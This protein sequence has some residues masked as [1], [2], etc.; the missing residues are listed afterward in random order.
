MN[1]R[2]FL[3]VIGQG[4]AAVAGM[5]YIPRFFVDQAYAQ[6]ANNLKIVNIFL[7][8][9]CDWFLTHE[10]TGDATFMDTLKQ[11]RPTLSV[12]VAPRRVLGSTN[13]TVH[14]R[15]A[16]FETAY[17][18]GELAVVM[19][20]GIP[21]FNSGSHEEATN[22]FARGL[23]NGRTT[24]SAGWMQRVAAKYF[25]DQFQ[26]LDLQ[27]GSASTTGGNFRGVFV[28]NLSTFGFNGAAT[29]ESGF[30]LSSAFAA[31]QQ[32]GANPEEIAIQNAWSDT[33]KTVTAVASAVANTTL[34]PVFPTTSIGNQLRDAFRALTNFPTRLVYTATGGYD[35]HSMAD[36]QGQQVATPSGQSRL[37]RDLNDAIAAFKANCVRVG[38]WNDIAIVVTSEF[39]RTNR[40][41]GNTGVDHADANAS[42]IIGGKVNG[43]HYGVAPTS[44]DLLRPQ[45]GIDAKVAVADIY[46]D[47]IVG[48]G[49]DPTPVFPTL[50]RS[51]LGILKA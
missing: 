45:N 12:P 2:N 15:L 37:L 8:G 30:R 11:I 29:G 40:E 47:L 50:A 31:I 5:S 51:P 1:R 23:T 34:N 39:A 35:V 17:N 32:A 7:A 19:S 36:P 46:A 27:G 33:E 9:G 21:Q 4:S 28:N 22:H 6:A 49:L 16:E 42:Y 24:E 38:I 3:K 13:Y 26:L 25:Q 44:A 14:N 20:T 18:A 48:M 43:G 41:N 10:P